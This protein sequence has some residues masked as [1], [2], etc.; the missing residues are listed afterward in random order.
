MDA[1]RVAGAVVIV[2]CVV[3]LIYTEVQK[4]LV[5][6]KYE[7]LFARQDF[8]GCVEL[9][10]RPLVRL[11]FPRYNRLFMR[12]NAQMCLDNAQEVRRV[13]D[14]MLALR[15]TAEQ[16]MALL[17]RAFNFFVEQ[18]EYKRAKKVLVELREK[19]T[20]EVLAECERTY[21]IFAN[22]SSAYIHEM[23]ERLEGAGVAERT[24]LCYLLSVQY[25]NTGDTERAAEYLAR[26]QEAF[27]APGAGE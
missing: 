10:D 26:A 4:R 15:V 14:E 17:V 24:A 3:S 1:V 13:I 20:P 22:K 23:R 11:L 12:L 8:A 21:D 2:A 7:A 5:F 9:L 16:R 25:E 6:S 19:A 18:E 27:E